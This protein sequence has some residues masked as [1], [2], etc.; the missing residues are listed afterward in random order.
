MNSYEALYIL[1]IQGKDEGLKEAM[2][3]IEQDIQSL[4]G[5][6]SGSQKMDRRKFE[7]VAGKLDA[8]FYLGMNFTLDPAKI[9]ELKTRLKLNNLVY[10]QFYLRSKPLKETVAA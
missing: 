9:D 4:G 5:T 8:G 10:R 6:V 2:D 3:Q 7:N 1:D